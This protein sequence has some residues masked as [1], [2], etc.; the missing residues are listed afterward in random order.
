MKVL[1]QILLLIS[2]ASLGQADEMQEEFSILPMTLK[3]AAME[4]KCYPP[5]SH[6]SNYPHNMD[7]ID[8]PYAFGYIESIAG[9]G[10]H[11]MGIYDSSAVYWCK[12]S[13]DNYSLYYWKD[14]FN[15]W[16]ENYFKDAAK[17]TLCPNLITRDFDISTGVRIFRRE[18]E[19]SD[20]V[21]PLNKKYEHEGI[22]TETII[23]LSTDGLSFDFICKGNTWL[24]RPWD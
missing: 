1:M 2:F 23:H 12:V 6:F 13:E 15:L 19:L 7:V 10:I 14:E 22:S 11:G 20:Y 5:N 24:M 4:N 16:L 9:K 3:K 18:V 8:P 17:V 21:N